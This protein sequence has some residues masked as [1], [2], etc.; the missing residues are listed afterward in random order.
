MTYARRFLCVLTWRRCAA[1]VEPD[2][3]TNAI[4]PQLLTSH[5][6][7]RS[8]FV[9]FRDLVASLKRRFETLGVAGDAV[10]LFTTKIPSRFMFGDVPQLVTLK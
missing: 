5:T 9:I 3:Y 1:C 2:C 10:G 4:Q 6:A 7:M 8:P